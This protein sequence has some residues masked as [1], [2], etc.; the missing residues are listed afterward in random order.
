VEWHN[1]DHRSSSSVHYTF[2]TILYDPVH[3]PTPTGDGEIEFLYQ[4]VSHTFGMG[5]DNAYWTTGIMSNDH[6]D[7]LQYSYWNGYHPAASVIESNRALKF[8]TVEPIRELQVHNFELILEP[9]GLPITIPSNGGSFD[10][11]FEITNNG[12]NPD[13]ADF[14]MDLTLPDGSTSE[15]VFI[16]YTFGIGA[17]VSFSRDMNQFVPA[18]APG[19]D[20][21]FNAY[22]GSYSSGTIFSEDHFDFDKSGFDANGGGEWLLTGWEEEPAGITAVIQL[23]EKY[24]LSS[25]SPNPFNPTTNLSF[26]LPEAGRVKLLVFNTLGR[27]VATLSDGWKTAGWHTAAFDGSQLSSGIYFYTLQAG[28]FIQTKKMLLVK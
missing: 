24:E 23:P 6:L 19:G 25:A 17:G 18:R 8:T 16:R 15:P 21:T 12:T 3:H 28:D 26:A 22:A 4:Q 14:W 2:E 11:N 7:G 9:E 27:Q 20:Y 13:T 10:F 1:I 5:T